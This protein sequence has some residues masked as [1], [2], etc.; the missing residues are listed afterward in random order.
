MKQRTT[1]RVLCA[2]A[3]VTVLLSGTTGT[4][5]SQDKAVKEISATAAGISPDH[6][7]VE[8]G[9]SCVD[10]HSVKLDAQTTATK[11]WLSGDYLK[12][13]AGEG[14]MGQ[15]DVKKAF[16]DIVGGRKDKRTFVL[17]TCINNTPLTTTADFTLDPETMTIYGMHEKGT[18]KLFHI[19]QNPRVSMNWHEEFK[20]WGKVL[21]VQV[22]G[23][24]VLLEGSD[25]EFER[26]LTGCVPYEELAA[27]M[28]LD[29][30]KARAMVKAGMVMSKITVDTVTINNSAFEQQGL[31]K[32]QRWEREAAPAKTTTQE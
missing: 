8:A 15:D 11:V 31:R 24:A 6:P 7:E 20:S 9:L 21:C 29:L 14:V 30:E 1:A 10:C 23:T 26:V 32:Y 5:F 4:A 18:T 3:A 2:A 22:I 19:Q 27:A 17:G 28:K 12:Y 16:V 13:A 25:P